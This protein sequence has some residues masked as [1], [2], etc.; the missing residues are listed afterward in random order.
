VLS[1]DQCADQYVLALS[2]RGAIVGLSPRA[3]DADS[4]LRARASGLPVRRADREVA[5]AVRPQIVVRYWGGDP[6]LLTD[7]RR[8]GVTVVQIEDAVEFDGIR[9]N[10]R[11]VAAALGRGAAGE[12]LIRIMDAKLTASRGAWAGRGAIYLTSGGAT[13]GGK[14]LV[15]AIL[16]A[17]GL[18]NLTLGQGYRSVSLERLALNPPQA[19]IRGFFDP[20][21]QS[22][23]HWG[24]GASGMLGRLTAKQTLVSLPGALLGCPAWF[25]ADAV[26]MIAAAAPTG[27]S[28]GRIGRPDASAGR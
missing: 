14:T 16:R 19:V 2:P 12:A 17:G 9:R 23:G 11:V 8:G 5:L 13:A 15:D 25:A 20:A 4:L 26:V 7:L 22:E 28:A 6:S 3:R 24:A 18:R 27:N 21:S 1:L 10:V